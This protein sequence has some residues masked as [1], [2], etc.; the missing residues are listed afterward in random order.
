MGNTGEYSLNRIVKL[1]IHW[2]LFSGTV[3]G[4]LSEPLSGALEK[5]RAPAEGL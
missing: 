5:A 3:P 4:R 1:E 2:T